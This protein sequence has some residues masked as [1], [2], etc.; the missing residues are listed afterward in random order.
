M[1]AASPTSELRRVGFTDPAKA[2]RLLD[3]P[4]LA[5]YDV[6]EVAASCPDPDEGLLALTRLAEAAPEELQAAWAKPHGARRLFAL[7]GMSRP[8]GDLLISHPHWLAG[9]DE[10]PARINEEDEQRAFEKAVAGGVEGIRAHYYR[11]LIDIAARDLTSP[12]PMGQVAHVAEDLA[13]LVGATLHGALVLARQLT[14]EKAPLAVIAMGKTGGLELN[15]ISDVDVV[16]VTLDEPDV[17]GAT[18]LARSIGEIVSQP[19]T[20]RPLWPLDA[21]LRPEGKDGPLVRTLDSYRA[22]YERWAKNWEFQA[23]LKARFVSGDKQLGTSFLDLTRPYVWSASGRESFVESARSMRRRVEDTLA[24]DEAPRQLKLGKGGLRDV[25][26]T[27]QLLQLVHGRVD[28]TLRAP[29]TLDALAALRDGG[30][31]GR[32]DAD[33]LD[34]AYRFLRTLEHRIQLQRL[35][36]SHLVPEKESELRRL[37][38]S[39]SF[40]SGE[41]LE[42]AWLATR[43]DVRRLHKSIFYRPLLPEA[44]RL[45]DDD[46]SLDDTAARDRLGAIGYRDPGRALDHIAALTEGLSRSAKIQRQLLPVLL[47][48]FTAGPEPDAGLLHFRRLSEEMGR[49][50]WYLKLL[51]DSGVAAKR[52]AM[53]LSTSRYLAE[54]IPRLPESVA[55]LA[56]DEDLVPHDIE[57]LRVELHSLISRRTDPVEIAQ[58]GR[59]LRRR[60][61]LRSGLAISTG[62]IG[63]GLCRR[64]ITTASEVALEAALVAARRQVA[65]AHDIS[66]EELPTLAIIGMGS[67]G[68]K[69]M[70]H[71]SDADVIF[72]H[73]AAGRHSATDR[74]ASGTAEDE[75]DDDSARLAQEL[76]EAVV[77]LARQGA[78]EPPL[79][80]DADLRPEGRNGP[81]T[82]SLASYAEYYE[83]WG[84]TW[85]RQALLKARPVAG[86]QDLGERFIELI[87][88][89]RYGE[90]LSAEERRAIRHMKARVEAERI[91]R[92]VAKTRQL[93]LGPGAI[94]DVEWTA[95]YLQLAHAEHDPA[96]RTTSTLPALEAAVAGGYIGEAEGQ[97][98]AESW[99]Y[100]QRLRMAVALGTGRTSGSR[101]DVLPHEAG[102]LTTIAAMLSGSTRPDIDETYLR[103]TRRA[104]RVVEKIFF[105]AS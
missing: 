51:R 98:L 32:S 81:L 63:A 37:A 26:F 97:A 69:E 84:E 14:G 73:E 2:A 87:E 4:C 25:E 24:P 17:P 67:L 49:T 90:G 20:L 66:E 56:A 80:I 74:E 77:A 40:P 28:D 99:A 44:A 12:D 57:D 92:G 95:Q 65:G 3:A 38:R 13:R 41:A 16:F 5:G 43:R 39:L 96:L 105:P 83:R 82:R 53:I 45:S 8:L 86:D 31:V 76:A 15:Y 101:V 103:L 75:G 79:V 36:R 7:L 91:P 70:S 29:R 85:E 54:Q 60:G 27:V 72:V 30:Y 19:G 102:E 6:I 33:R 1:R 47:G 58:A 50:H 42:E 22:Y 88:P 62:V 9:L 21:D 78:G 10:A 71:S 100:A 89:I 35:R 93:K 64:A 18:R 68:A 23:L 59:Y 34:E 61:L 94:A 46:I 11:R 52:L 55:W 104:R 48:W